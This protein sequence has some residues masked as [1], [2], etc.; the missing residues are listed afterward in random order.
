MFG[1]ERLNIF[2]E[3][4]GVLMLCRN[5]G[6]SDR[7]NLSETESPDGPLIALLI[8]HQSIW[9]FIPSG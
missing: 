9:Q 1:K 7:K 8:N 3:K 6:E 2:P 4:D 5:A